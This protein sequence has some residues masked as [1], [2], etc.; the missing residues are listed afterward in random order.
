[1]QLVQRVQMEALTNHLFFAT[2][3]YQNSTM[4][5]LTCSSGY[6][7]RYADISDLQKMFKRLRKYNSFGRPF[8]YFAVSERGSRTA[9]P[10][11]HIIF[12]LPK[13]ENDNWMDILNLEYIVKTK[14]LEQWKRNISSTRNPVYVELCKYVQKFEGGI[15]RSTYD[16]HYVNP[17]N[18]SDSCSSVAFYAIKYMLKPST[19]ETRLQQALKL[20]LPEDEYNSVWNIVRSRVIYSKDFG[21]SKSEKVQS[22]IKDCVQ[23]SKSVSDSKFPMFFNPDDGKSFPLAR[24]YKSKGSL[25]SFNDALYW[26]DLNASSLDTIVDDEKSPLETLTNYRSKILHYEKN[27]EITSTPTLVDLGDELFD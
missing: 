16:C 12:M 3:T 14:V 8:K 2:L 13:Y 19:N 11:F 5:R 20:N 25:Y 26:Y 7:F 10:H 23:H 27:K 24:F 17:R 4:P 9:R 18:G 21:N 1:M 15:L 22:Y 6:E